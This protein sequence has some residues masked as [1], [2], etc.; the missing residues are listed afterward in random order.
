[1]GLLLAPSNQ[2]TVVS[3]GSVEVDFTP[4]STYDWL[5]NQ[6]AIESNSV[7]FSQA[8]VFLNQKFMCGSNIGNQDAADGS[9]II[10]RNGS[11][12]RIVWSGCTNGSLCI[13]HLIVEQGVIG[14][15]VNQ[16]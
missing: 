8:R 12:L 16:A 15:G 3:G 4:P 5:V 14:S 10:V 9:P 11:T 13:A 7:L 6:I 2:A 1:M